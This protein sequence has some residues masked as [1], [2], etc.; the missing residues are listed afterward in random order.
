MGF[1]LGAGAAFLGCS[2]TGSPLSTGS[3]V[4]LFITAA[5]L[6]VGG[7]AWGVGRWVAERSAAEAGR[8]WT[9]LEEVG[10]EIAWTCDAD[11]RFTHASTQ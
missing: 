8:R 5:T 7:G 2:L 10:E 3:P 6:T 9:M 1:A 4:D 11:G